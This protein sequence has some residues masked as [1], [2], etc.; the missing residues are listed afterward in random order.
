MWFLGCVED[1][2]LRRWIVYICVDDIP[3]LLGYLFLIMCIY[4][5]GVQFWV[6]LY[7]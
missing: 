2:I 6:Y 7:T 5:I 4:T 3:T 1:L